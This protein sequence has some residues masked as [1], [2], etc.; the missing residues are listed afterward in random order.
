M[1]LRISTLEDYILPLKPA[2]LLESVPAD[3]RQLRVGGVRARAQDTYPVH[4]SGLLRGG[5]KRPCRCRGG[6]KEDE[7]P[8]S[9]SITSSAWP[10]SRGREREGAG[11]ASFNHLGG[12]GEDRGRDG[13]AECLGGVEIDDQLEGRRLL[14]RQI[15]RLGALENLSGVNAELAVDG[16]E[17]GSIA[18]QAA[19]LGEL[20][21]L[22]D[23]RN[24]M[25]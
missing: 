13:E 18:D 19:G 24:A 1:V 11:C 9:H 15:G 7:L 2:E 14:D 12:A 17:A 10:R 22:V 16:R 20:T 5:R 8:P 23:R 25:A 6:Y 4:F 21:P 3:S